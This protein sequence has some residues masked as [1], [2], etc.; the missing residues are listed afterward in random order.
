LTMFSTAEELFEPPWTHWEITAD[1][2]RFA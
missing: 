1:L 2:E